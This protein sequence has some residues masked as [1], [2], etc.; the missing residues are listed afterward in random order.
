[1]DAAPLLSEFLSRSW[2][3]LLLRGVVAILFGIA[4]IAWPGVTA[5]TFVTIFAAFALVDGV[6]DV[7][8]AIRFRKDLEHWG[9]SLIAGLFGIAFG[10]LALAAPAATT[11]VG[12]VIVALYVAGWAIVTG[13]LR[14]AMAIRLRKEIEGEWLLGLSGALAILLGIWIM[15]HPAAG[16]LAMLTMIA[17]FA[18]VFGLVLVVLAFKVKKLGKNLGKLAGA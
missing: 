10:V 13:A 15:A 6:C 5:V 3:I 7:I 18:I 17:I 4:A 2:W 14:I 16:V 11:A 8:H 1:M 12:S 9:L